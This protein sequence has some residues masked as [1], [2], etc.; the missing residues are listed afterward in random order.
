MSASFLWL[1]HVIEC[2]RGCRHSRPGAHCPIGRVKF[3][4]WQQEG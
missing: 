1:R 2:R 3:L 4:Q